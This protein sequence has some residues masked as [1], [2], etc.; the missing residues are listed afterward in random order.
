MLFYKWTSFLGFAFVIGN[1]YSLSLWSL[2]FRIIEW[3]AGVGK[4]SILKL[5]WWLFE[6][7]YIR[8]F[9][10]L[11]FVIKKEFDDLRIFIKIVNLKS[12]Q[13][14]RQMS[15]LV[16]QSKRNLHS[17][18]TSSKLSWTLSSYESLFHSSLF[19]HEF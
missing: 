1:Y 3:F 15:K 11:T 9:S 7:R 5:Q 10:A 14:S 16:F 4:F 13:N 12:P 6:S 8:F 18:K 17:K 19:I 2:R